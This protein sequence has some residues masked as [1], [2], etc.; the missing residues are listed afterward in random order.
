[1]KEK[2]VKLRKQGFSYSEIRE[3]VPVSKSTL[4][5]W[6]R[7]ITLTPKQKER[8]NLKM[9]AN[10][11]IGAQANKQK[12]INRTSVIMDKAKSEIKE[13]AE[14]ER[15]LMGIMLYW[16]EG[17]KQRP[18]NIGQRVSFNNSDPRMIKFY[19]SWLRKSLK[20]TDD[21]FDFEIYIHENIRHKERK[22]I[23]YWSKVTGFSEDR[24]KKIYYKTDK[25]RKY[26]KNQGKNYYGLLR[27]Y[28]R[29]STDLNRK[30]AG[31]IIGISEI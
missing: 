7:D 21:L 22:V 28:V 18:H 9:V 26:R 5:L 1:M 4:S 31:W 25:K 10:Q 12:R 19:L 3:K 14:R 23:D 20:I 2:A 27:I 8:L 29:K 16:A 24:F 15:W 11:H 17:S 30:I 13:I 6:L